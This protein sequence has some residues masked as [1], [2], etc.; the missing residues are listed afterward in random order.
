VNND[1]KFYFLILFFCALGFFWIF[2]NKNDLIPKGIS[3]CFIKN[4]S[5]FPCPTCGTTRSIIFLINGYFHRSLLINP[6]GILYFF[7]ILLL[8]I[9]ILCDLVFSKKTLLN[10]YNGIKL[11]VKKK[12]FYVILV[13]LI[14]I[15]WVWNIKKGL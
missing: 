8:P 4:V 14:C 10:F 7:F 15:N 1:R 6:L 3:F 5:G 13:I 11:K 9:W 12:K 2:F